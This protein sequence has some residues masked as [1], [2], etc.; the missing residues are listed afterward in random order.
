VLERFCAEVLSGSLLHVDMGSSTYF[1]IMNKVPV[2]TIKELTH[3]GQD[4]HT[5]S[6]TLYGAEPTALG[7]G[8]D[9]D[10]DGENTDEELAKKHSYPKRLSGRALYRRASSDDVPWW[11]L[12]NSPRLAQ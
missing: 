6:Q 3:V 1:D 9:D 11:P 8:E 10:E 2:A 12:D 4:V 5:K 7:D